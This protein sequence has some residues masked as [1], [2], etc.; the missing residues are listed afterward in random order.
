MHPT[1]TWSEITLR[2]ILTILAA[3]VIGFNRD[4]HGRPAGLRTNLLVSLAACIAM[5]QTNILAISTGKSSDSFVVM[6]IMRLPLGILSGIGFIGAGAIVKRGRLTVGLTTA[7]T[8][9]FLTVMGLCFGGGQIG[10]GLAAFVVCFVVLVGMKKLE[11]LTS[12]EQSATLTVKL[13]NEGAARGE[14]EDLLVQAGIRPEMSALDFD[15]SGC[16]VISWNIRWRDQKQPA[17]AP[18]VI[19]QLAKRDEIQHVEFRRPG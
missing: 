3:G 15:P 11:N 10:L 1:V 6:D 7:A 16:K 12:R 2:L 4:E 5:I 9:W 14:I 13:C 18:L 19:E 17:D 8:L